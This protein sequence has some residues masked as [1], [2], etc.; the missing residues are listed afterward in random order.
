MR[1]RLI[2]LGKDIIIALLTLAILVLLLLALPV[3]TLTGTPWLAAAVKPFAGLF[4]INEA[5]LTYVEA[6]VP[7]PSAAK[8]LAISVQNV[9]GRCSAVYDEAA[10]ESMYEPLGALLAQALDSAGEFQR[11]TSEQVYDA[12]RAPSAAFAY[13]S[14]LRA[15]VLVVG[16]TSAEPAHQLGPIALIV[17]IIVA[18]NKRDAAE[19]IGKRIA[20]IHKPKDKIAAATMAVQLH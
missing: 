6:A 8:P 17:P 9:T 16:I 3:K 1:R 10:L 13:S 15:D 11:T 18:I 4:G 2:E 20:S 19:I 12:L 5:E 14:E 7:A